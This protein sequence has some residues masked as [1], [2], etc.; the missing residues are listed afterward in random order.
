MNSCY[1]LTLADRCAAAA[2]NCFELSAITEFHALADEFARK[3]A[4]LE[5]VNPALKTNHAHE[6]V[7]EP[8]AERAARC[9]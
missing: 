5:S 6:K 7:Q 8:V 9:L 2:R 4:E 3:A 1:F